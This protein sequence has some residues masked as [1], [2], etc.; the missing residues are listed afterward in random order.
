MIQHGLWT[1]RFRPNNISEYVFKNPTQRAQIEK[2]IRDK[3]APH[4]LCYGPPG[5]GKTSI[6][7]MLI[8]ELEINKLDVL[9]INASRDKG[10][11][12]M[13]N[14]ITSFA[15]TLPFGD[16][17]IVFLD[18]ADGLTPASQDALKGII[19]Q[20]SM[21]CRFWLTSNHANKIIPAIHSRCQDF[22]IEKL[23]LD[24]YTARVAEILIAESIE[25]DLDVLDT[26]VRSSYPDL[27][28]C[29]NLVQL[30]SINNVLTSTSDDN[31]NTH[32]YLIDAI[33][34]FKI[35]K[36][37][38]GR[39]IICTRSRPDDGEKI[40][41]FLYDNLDFWGDNDDKKDQAII[42]IRKGLVNHTLCADSEINIS[43]VLTEL[44]QIR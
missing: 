34:L 27:R 40:F 7:W 1:E 11:D 44:G 23:D 41:R 16:L 24:D 26:Y 33:E 20:Y 3:D 37:R 38:E 22:P 32:D 35:G 9:Y 28:K 29:I 36:I 17:K 39:Q 12:D 14:K 18:E 13:R 42:I 4:L 8:N 10:I 43:A 5:T 6:F 2:W 31:G 30:N 25:F 21:A 15:S 19:E